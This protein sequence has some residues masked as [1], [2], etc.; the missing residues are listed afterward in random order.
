MQELRALK[1]EPRHEGLL[2]A[3]FRVLIGLS[4]GT[5]G[6]GTGRIQGY[7]RVLGFIGFVESPVMNLEVS[8]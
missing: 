3:G 7:G 4:L 8:G 6:F 1:V 2:V 5:V